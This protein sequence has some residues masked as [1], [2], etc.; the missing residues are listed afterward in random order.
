MDL[1]PLLPARTRAAPATATRRR[2]PLSISPPAPTRDPRLSARGAVAGAARP[3]VRA[4]LGSHG[5]GFEDP[6]SW[7]LRGAGPG[8]GAGP[9]NPRTL[10]SAPAAAAAQE[11]PASGL[12]RLQEP[13][14]LR[15]SGGKTGVKN[16]LPRVCMHRGCPGPVSRWSGMLEASVT[17]GPGAAA[18]LGPAARVPL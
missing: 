12:A 18:C 4:G 1:D 7:R 6:E 10:G 3:E 8:L 13:L 17:P 2:R 9:E 11:P 5:C 14:R 15:C 16:F